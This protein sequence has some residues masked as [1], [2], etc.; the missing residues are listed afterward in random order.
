LSLDND[1]YA[2]G[3]IMRI[4]HTSDWHLGRSLMNRRRYDEFDAFLNWLG[5]TIRTEKIDALIVAGDIFDT[6]LPSNRAQEQYYNFLTKLATSGTC[7]DIILVGGN[8]DS[9]SF[10]KAPAAL[11]K[12]LNIYMVGA[13]SNDIA[14]DIIILQQDGTPKAIICAVPYLRDRDIRQ[15]EIGE[16]FDQKGAKLLQG[17]KLHYQNICEIAKQKRDELGLE[18]PIVTTGHLFADGGQIT[19]GDGVRELYVGTLARI[20]VDIF[21]DFV[22]YVALGHLHIPQKVGGVD[23]IRYSGSPLPM[24]FG[25]A[26]QQKQVVIVDFG[27]QTT[28]K[29][30]NIPQFQSLKSIK[31]DL[32][33]ITS[34]INKLIAQD[35]NIWLEIEYNGDDIV[36]NLNDTITDLVA[37]SKLEVLRVKNQRVLNA[38]LTQYDFSVNLDDLNETDVFEKFLEINKIGAEE[39]ENLMPAYQQILQIVSETDFNEQ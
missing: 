21:P 22:D 32:V 2:L 20:G 29:E 38:I 10:L 12:A 26:E 37:G 24:G 4:L 33:E 35:Q 6:T 34:A 7:K 18:I 39:R 8:H 13:I 36:N 14:D 27:A 3:Q 25:E 9:P 5:E 11:L 30:I 1:K 23:K 16:S 28:I 15:S 19:E 17:I 31:G